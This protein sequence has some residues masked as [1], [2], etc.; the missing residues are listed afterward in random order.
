M[1]DLDTEGAMISNLALEEETSKIAVIK[2]SDKVEG[3]GDKIYSPLCGGLYNEEE[4]SL[5]PWSGT[6]PDS[7]MN[8]FT[9]YKEND[10]WIV[11]E[12]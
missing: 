9:W 2:R 10:D 11:P 3:S 7:K 4:D 1:E 6:Y 5:H 12:D 8:F